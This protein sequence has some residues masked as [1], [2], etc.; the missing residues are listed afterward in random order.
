ME[1]E[2]PTPEV[3]E[4]LLRPARYKGA[5]GGRGSGKSHFF[6][7]CLI[8]ASIIRKTDAVCIREVQKSLDQSVEKLIESKIEALNVG[9]YFEVQDAV[10]K[11]R[12][13]GRI[14]FQGMQNHTADSIK[15]LEGYDIAWIEEAQTL[16]KKSLDLLRPTMRKDGSEIWASWNPYSEDDPIDQ[17]FRGDNVFKNAISVMANYSDNPFFPKE[18][19]DEME[20][21]RA[22]DFEKYLHVWEGAYRQQSEAVVF[23][24]WKV[25]EFDA[26]SNAVF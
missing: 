5:Y 8:E 17:F 3:F 24:N 25:L 6:A 15:S 1:L 26:P 4:P 20:F 12:N 18:L 21:D 19:K 16:S 9:L 11:S 14:I 7:E 13:G 10:I 2:L 23:K 22:N